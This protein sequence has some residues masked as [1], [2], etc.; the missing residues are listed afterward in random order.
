MIIAVAGVA[1]SFPFRGSHL[2]FVPNIFLALVTG[3][4]IYLTNDN[5]KYMW[6]LISC[7]SLVFLFTL[8][9]E[10]LGFLNHTS[11]KFTELTLAVLIAA[12][13]LYIYQKRYNAKPRKNA[14]D[15]IKFI[16]I[17]IL[18]INPLMFFSCAYISWPYT[19]LG[20][21]LIPLEERLHVYEDYLFHH[22]ILS[23]YAFLLLYIT[24][25]FLIGFFLFF[26]HF[27]ND[28]FKSNR[29]KPLGV[30]I[31][32]ILTISCFGI[33]IF[34]LHEKGIADKN[35]MLAEE[36]RVYAE[37]AKMKAQISERK[38]KEAELEAKKQLEMYRELLEECK[39]K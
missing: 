20:L 36:Q 21:D 29:M 22:G 15:T 28:Q 11:L 9:S 30:I 33:F 27:L 17:V 1:M 34:G 18:A 24:P 2:F 32:V 5:K 19:L 3:I 12:T 25:L 31:Y 39:E 6:P 26:Y 8:F 37:E 23:G 7:L 13:T 16:C 10:F 4:Y 38:A 35:R 14:S